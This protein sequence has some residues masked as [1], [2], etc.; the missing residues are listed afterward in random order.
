MRSMTRR[1]FTAATTSVVALTV[2]G[3]DSRA[4]QTENT[5]EAMSAAKGKTNDKKKNKA[6]LA[7]EPFLVGQP[8]QYTKLGVYTEYKD[9]K[10]VWLVSD[11]RELVALS[12]TCTHLACSTDYDPAKGQFEC[13]CHESRFSLEGKNDKYAKAKRP[14]ERCTVRLVDGQIEVDP[15]RRLRQEKGE[16]SDAAAALP[17]G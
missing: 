5:P 15:T 10:G 8:G 2:L 12:A 4:D 17:L 9:D 16:W 14:L 6:N 1:E 7:T 3:C 13:P 11:G